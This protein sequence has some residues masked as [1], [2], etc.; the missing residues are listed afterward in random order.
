ML[1]GPDDQ[2]ATARCRVSDTIRVGVW[3]AVWATDPMCVAGA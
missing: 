3:S 2:S 1:V